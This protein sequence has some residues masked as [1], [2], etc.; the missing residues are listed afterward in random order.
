M[1]GGL[2]RLLSLQSEAM[3]DADAEFTPKVYPGA[4]HAFFNDSNPA[5]YDRDAAV[6]AWTRTLDFLARSL[7]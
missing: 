2:G 3:A 5:T 6:D 7:G 4:R 1:K